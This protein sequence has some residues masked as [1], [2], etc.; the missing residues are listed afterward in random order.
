MATYTSDQDIIALSGKLLAEAAACDGGPDEEIAKLLREAEGMVV[1][2]QSERDTEISRFVEHLDAWRR[3]NAHFAAEND[4]LQAEVNR[5][6][7]ALLDNSGVRR[8]AS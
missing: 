5:L 4:R 1:Q 2:L 6:T 8:V 7:Q 3:N